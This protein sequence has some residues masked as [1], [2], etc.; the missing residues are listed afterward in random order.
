MS[1]V[2]GSFSNPGIIHK[3]QFSFFPSGLEATEKQKI[4]SAR[5]SRPDTRS[6]AGRCRSFRHVAHRCNKPTLLGLCNHRG[7]SQPM[8]PSLGD[9][10]NSPG[11][12]QT[13]LSECVA[14]YTLEYTNKQFT[15]WFILYIHVYTQ[16]YMDIHIHT[17][18]RT[19]TCMHIHTYAY[20]H[21]HIHIQ[22]VYPCITTLPSHLRWHILLGIFV[23]QGGAFSA[24]QIAFGTK[25]CANHWFRGQ[26]LNSRGKT[27]TRR[28]A[29][30]VANQSLWS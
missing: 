3:L 9:S 8:K 21:M 27:W 29:Q 17:Y 30:Q 22:C 24:A 11:Y 1:T 2:S 18:T 16:V 13:G 4:V 28:F 14:I 12:L 5:S 23:G 25:T 15:W 6:A 26:D 20:I 19:Y 7:P 10:G